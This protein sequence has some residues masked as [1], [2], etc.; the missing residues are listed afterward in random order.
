M[1][2]IRAT[3]WWLGALLFA[4]FALPGYAASP[5]KIFSISMAPQVLSGGS[6]SLQATIKNESPNGNSTINSLTIAL[7]SG[8]TIDS[9]VTPT[10]NW[11]GQIT[12]TAASISMSNLTPL[13]PQVSF[14]LTFQAIAPSATSG[15]QQS[16]WNAQAWTGSSFAG[17]TFAQLFPPN[18]TAQPYTSVAS[19]ESLAFSQQPSNVV[20]GSA[21]SPAVAVS[22]STSCGPV[23]G[24][25][26][27]SAGSCTVASGCLSGNTSTSSHGSASFSILKIGTPG[28]YTLTASSPGFSTVA[29]LPFTVFAGTLACSPSTNPPST[30]ESVPTGVGKTDPGYAAGYRGMYNKNGDGCVVVPY[31]FTNTILNDDTVQ[32]AW[33]TVLQP[34]ATFV[35]TMNWRLRSVDSTG[36]SEVRPY[37]AWE[38]DKYTIS[39]PVYVPGLACLSASLPAPYGTLAA[40]IGSVANADTQISITTTATLPP[41]PFPIDVGTERME[42]TGAGSSPGTYTVVRQTGRT[43]IAAHLAGAQVMSTPLPIDPNPYL[44][45]QLYAANTDNPYWGAQAHMCIVSQQWTSAG[46]DGNGNAQVMPSTTVFDIGDGFVTIR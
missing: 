2:V 6:V 37:V 10:T 1:R 7:P 31:T 36:W 22:L 33:D 38:S 24:T 28:T 9:T 30:F 40:D 15:C 16:T 41:F 18:T 44:P 27:L 13:K 26:T 11:I 43:L 42:V 17:D 29:S 21:I 14:V 34:Y 19:S 5:Q 39:G 45:T 4:A 35:Y 23:D 3:I 8:Y 25:V 46:N 12:T 32:L 20:E